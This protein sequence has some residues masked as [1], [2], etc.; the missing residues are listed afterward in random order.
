MRK[1]IA[2][3]LATAACGASLT[4]STA[5]DAVAAEHAPQCVKVR[6]SFDKDQRHYLRLANLCSRRTSCFTIVVPHAKD[7]HGR[8]RRS[9]TK[10]VPY[11]PVKGPRALY[12]KNTHC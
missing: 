1:I 4:L 9:T 11:G 2:I 7:P 6:K 3:A 10:D 8:L 5:S 12:V